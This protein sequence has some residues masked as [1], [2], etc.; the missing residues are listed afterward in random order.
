MLE[1]QLMATSNL[2]L[3]FWMYFLYTIIIIVDDWDVWDDES[4]FWMS[5]QLMSL[6]S[7]LES[8]VIEEKKRKEEKDARSDTKKSPSDLPFSDQSWII[9]WD[10]WILRLLDWLAGT[11]E[12]RANI[13]R[14]AQ[15]LYWI[16]SAIWQVCRRANEREKTLPLFIIFCGEAPVGICTHFIE[17]SKKSVQYKLIAF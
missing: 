3:A 17:L 7:W 4:F 2:S 9:I 5:S 13:L 11:E 16:E 12:G 6:M 1:Q 14:W 10:W 8:I 15:T